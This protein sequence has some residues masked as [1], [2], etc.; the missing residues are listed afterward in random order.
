MYSKNEKITLRQ[1]KCLIVFDFFGVLSLIV[2]YVISSSAGYDGLGAILVAALLLFL[3][4]L[5]ITFYLKQLERPYLSYTKETIG[6]F[7]TAIF[8]GLYLIK[9]F[10][11][12][13]MILRLFISI[14]N[15]TILLDYSTISIALPLIVVAGYMTYKGMEARARYAEIMYY[16]VLIPVLILFLLTLKDVDIANLTPVF[17]TNIFSTAKAGFVLFLLFNEIELLL[18]IK[19]YVKPKKPSASLVTGMFTHTLKGLICILLISGLVFALTVG[20]LG[21]KAS[22]QSLWSAVSILQLTHLPW[23][24]LNRQDAILI[25]LWLLTIFSILSGLL[26]YMCHVTKH[27]FNKQTGKCI[28]PLLLVFVFLASVTPVDINLFYEYYMKYMF[29]IGLPQSILLPFIPIFIRKIKPIKIKTIKHSVG[30]G[31]IMVFLFFGIGIGLSGCA[32]QVE[33]EDRDFVQVFGVDYYNGIFSAYYVLPDLA[34]V[35]EQESS[36]KETLLRNY[37]GE[38]LYEVEEQYKTSSE[39]KLDYRHLKAIVLGENLT[40]NKEVLRQFIEYC[41]NHYEIS[42]NTVVFLTDSSL[43]QVMNYNDKVT[44]GLGNYLTRLHDNNLSNSSKGEVYLGTLVNDR[45][46]T[47][48]CIHIPIISLHLNGLVINGEGIVDNSLLV[49]K[50]TEEQSKYTDI[51]RG[52]GNY[53][54]IFLKGSYSDGGKSQ[55]IRLSELRNSNSLILKNG[56]PYLRVQIEGHG[57]IEQGEEDVLAYTTDKRMEAYHKLEKEVDAQVKAIMEDQINR[58]IKEE[59][60]DYLNILRMSRYLNRD[61]YSYY[62]ERQYEF[63]ENLKVEVVVDFTLNRY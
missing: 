2:P 59:S 25:S 49:A 24:L 22:S 40:K 52:F 60:I 27:V 8:C 6:K 41:E 31:M 15:T 37:Q 38:N 5:I 23:S 16:I 62:K 29:Y 45:N 55:I 21:E 1:L 61:I 32:N 9:F 47:D 30:K 28:L 19:P 10:F 18:F 43:W 44:D 56:I 58:M 4:L 51:L 53:S 11:T 34:A 12:T 39:K 36:D 33:I 42:K 63:L 54:R 50:L 26:Y 48:L 13:V 57:K 20:L 46:N 14:I 35:S 17:A 3:Y 7:F